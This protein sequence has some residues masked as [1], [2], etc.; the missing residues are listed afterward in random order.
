MNKKLI[1]AFIGLNIFAPANQEATIT[2]NDQ[3]EDSFE[4]C[5][6]A[7]F[8]K[9]EN[10][11]E[12]IEKC[13]TRLQNQKGANLFKYI[14]K[15]L[16]QDRYDK[17]FPKYEESPED[18][19]DLSN[20]LKTI[21]DY[22]DFY[23]FYA[24]DFLYEAVYT[25]N[26]TKRYII[27]LCLELEENSNK[28]LAK[29]LTEFKQFFENLT[30]DHDKEFPKLSVRLQ[31]SLNEFQSVLTT[32]T[33]YFKEEFSEREMWR[34]HHENPMH[35]PNKAFD[36]IKNKLDQ[37]LKQMQ[38]RRSL[39]FLSSVFENKSD[40]KEKIGY[41]TNQ[42]LEDF[43]TTE[44]VNYSK[45]WIHEIL[46]SNFSFKE[47]DKTYEI[48][49]SFLPCSNEKKILFYYLLNLEDDKAAFLKLYIGQK[50]YEKLK[51]EYEKQQTESKNDLMTTAFA[52]DT[53][54]NNNSSEIFQQYQLLWQLGVEQNLRILNMWENRLIEIRKQIQKIQ[55]EEASFRNEIQDG[56]QKEYQELQTKMVWRLEE[57][58]W[59]EREL[60]RI[61]ALQQ[62]NEQLEQECRLELEQEEQK[63]RKKTLQD[64]LKEAAQSLLINEE[65]K[66]RNL[67][68]EEFISNLLK[69]KKK[70]LIITNNINKRSK[71]AYE[72]ESID[73]NDDSDSD[74][75]DFDFDFDFSSNSNNHVEQ[76]SPEIAQKRKENLKNDEVEIQIIKAKENLILEQIDKFIILENEEKAERQTL[77]NKFEEKNKAFIKQKLEA[78]EQDE[79]K[80]KWEREQQEEQERKARE[81]E[82]KEKKKRSSKSRKKKSSQYEESVDQE[83]LNTQEKAEK[84][85]M[86]LE[87]FQK[88]YQE[89]RKQI[90]DEE[91]AEY[92]K[93]K[94]E[95]Q[96]E[97]PEMK[98]QRQRNEEE[99][100][101]K[102]EEARQR[103]EE[104]GKR[105]A[106]E[107][108]AY[109]GVPF[110]QNKN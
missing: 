21:D 85:Q 79:R 63:A 53:T 75:F 59:K 52:S 84:R 4:S 66:T 101:R 12:F 41:F 68:L 71:N 42:E 78:A 69:L 9:K 37:Y 31:K 92:N 14:L 81:K 105:K 36:Y 35:L 7:N 54:E 6:I 57:T 83:Y 106:E 90:E 94:M 39:Y 67:I 22:Y 47:N 73:R 29:N 25:E 17:F 86:E 10:E 3:N 2:T 30:K 5:S 18:I 91:A 13:K 46:S 26:D 104:E 82:E 55:H 70:F 103:A 100:Q 48:K 109:Y 61:M 16:F 49:F 60:L 108:Q 11:I 28:T 62:D 74:D 99:K 50:T 96:K 98:K 95:H 56:Y 89:T 65:I 51:S 1:L 87:N 80:K 33:K 93:L 40:E 58:Q 97:D 20:W 107:Y 110:N 77:K 23:D 38:N 76:N 8:L 43:N 44:C 45:N 27:L 15:K 24:Y 64:K 32:I 34:M 19:K 88:K 102:K 72:A